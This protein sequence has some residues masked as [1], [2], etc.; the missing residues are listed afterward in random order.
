MKFDLAMLNL[1]DG[2]HTIKVKAKADGYRD[3]EFSN[4]VSYIRTSSVGY[5]MTFVNQSYGGTTS[6]NFSIQ[7]NGSGDWIEIASDEELH[8]YED[9]SYFKIYISNYVHLLSKALLNTDGGYPDHD[10][11]QLSQYN[12]TTATSES[13]A[14]TVTLTDTTDCIAEIF[15][16]IPDPC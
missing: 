8:E 6:N 3:S 11:P 10:N 15:T 9:V 13:T 1:T 12:L 16:Y 2:A 7:I 4:E 14:I 5:T